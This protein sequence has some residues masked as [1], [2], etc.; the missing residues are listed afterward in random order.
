MPRAKGIIPE[1]VV[2]HVINR[3][4]NRN[5][6]FHNDNDKLRYYTLLKELKDDNKIDI[7]HY[8]LMNNHTQII[9]NLNPGSTLSRF[10]KQLNLT[11]FHYYR[12]RYGY[13]GHLW[14]DR[15]KSN[16]IDLDSH[17]LQ[18]GKYIELNPVRA[19]ILVDTKG[20][21][22]IVNVKTTASIKI[23]LEHN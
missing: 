2:L 19:G 9:L 18:C 4:N 10:M 5:T 23:I 21:I 15:F 13:C 6:V 1:N 20:K 7:F 17:L 14:Q 8:C 16:I 11:Y 12:K 22:F 3:G